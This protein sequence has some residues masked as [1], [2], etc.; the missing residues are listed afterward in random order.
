MDR[1]D[2]QR[3][4]RE[5]WEH[6]EPSRLNDVIKFYICEGHKRLSGKSLL[7]AELEVA[8]QRER[9]SVKPCETLVLPVGFSL[10]PL[11]QSICVY[12]PQKVALL[13]NEAG[14]PGRTNETWDVFAQHVVEAVGYLVQKGLLSQ[15]PQ[16][17]GK[18]GG[19]GYPTSDSP[20]AVFQTLVE[21]LHDEVDVVI[22]V[23][24]GKKSMVSGTYMY[25]AYA[26]VRISY[27]DFDEYDPKHRCP[28]GYS[29]KIGELANPYAS[30]AL[31][32]WERVRALYERFQ[33]HEAT[34]ILNGQVIP[35]MKQVLP[36][37]EMPLQT[38]TTFLD[39]YEKWD[40]GDYRGAQQS[41][42]ALPDFNQPS[43][44]TRLGGQWFE[45][46]GSDFV[47]KPRRFY[48]DRQALQIYVCDE[49]ARIRRLIDY[50]EDYRSAFLR[51]GGVN[52][53]VMLARVV[54]SVTNSTERAALLNALE[55]RTPSVSSV[56]EALVKPPGKDITIGGD[57]QKDISFSNAPNLS[58]P[59]PA[60][61]NPWWKK[62]RLFNA[63]DG[64][65]LFLTRRNELAHKYFSVPKE[66]AEDAL[67]FVRANF[68]DFLGHPIANLNGRTTILPWTD[69]CNRCG[70]SRFLPLSLR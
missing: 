11:L 10:E 34:G 39:Y 35:A 44:V 68:E 30:F 47:S 27:V 59:H 8:R 6:F 33:F 52:E 22:D 3:I 69:L 41:A 2:I 66:W 67:A 43:A 54:E 60:A 24:G 70:L 12:H 37:S 23:T 62:T 40:Q 9:C 26:G 31:R 1:S 56:F 15:L 57:R 19:R 45:I 21:V 64:W 20:E 65:K 63:E 49:L 4:T 14:Y 36:A 55:D 18:N 25:A 29:C 53:I 28:Y 42:Q 50:N 38:L 7:E 17:P 13:L 32:E 5:Y 16:F 46:G 61:M 51:A 58:V 48:G